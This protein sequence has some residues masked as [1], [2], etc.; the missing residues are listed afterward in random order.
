MRTTSGHGQVSLAAWMP[1]APVLVPGVAEGARARAVRRSMDAMGE[2]SRRVVEA[3]PAVVV[4]ITP[5]AQREGWAYGLYRGETIHGSLDRFGVRDVHVEF[6]GAGAFTGLVQDSAERRGLELRWLPGDE[7]DHGAVVPLWHLRDAGWG[8]RTLVIGLNQSEGPGHTDLGQAIAEAARLGTV[9]IVVIASGDMSHRLMP[10][11]PAGYDPGAARFDAALVDCV[12]EGRLS[13]IRDLDPWVREMAAEDSVDSIW[14]AAAAVDWRSD[15][16]EVLSYE[17]PFGVGYGVGVLHSERRT[18][19]TSA[20]P[21]G[22]RELVG[23]ARRSIASAFA[24][25][26]P[27]V[28]PELPHNGVA[29]ERRAVFVTIHGVR[30][31][32]RGCVGSL[33][34]HCHCAAEEVWHLA[35]DAAFRDGRFRPLRRD[36]LVEI[37]LEVSVLDELEPART[38]DELDPVRYG[39]V[40]DAGDGR[41]GVLLP[42]V[43]GIDTVARQLEI[44]RRK[45]GI[46]A[47]EPVRMWRFTARRYAEG[48]GGDG[49]EEGV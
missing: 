40:V 22:G 12:R 33:T 45:A 30:G 4:L 37:R 41:R 1:H 47:D 35:R 42:G 38:T 39:V 34:P 14:V 43:E 46:G 20:D 13:A 5:H 10:G 9:P 23:V 31:D 18:E 8:G 17:G 44:A 11:A 6:P 3:R 29:G 26:G 49:G 7:L 21:E 28:P 16:H 19:E 2:V 15:R 36:E 48:D 32:L 24:G 27:G 25:G